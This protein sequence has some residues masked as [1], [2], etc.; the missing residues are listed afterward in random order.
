[1]GAPEAIAASAACMN[2]CCCGSAS[3]PNP[4]AYAAPFWS[5]VASAVPMPGN[6]P[7]T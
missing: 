6:A 5:V 1:M 2:S 3:G 7:T 4:G